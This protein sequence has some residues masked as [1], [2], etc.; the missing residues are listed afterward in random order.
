MTSAADLVRVDRT[1]H[2]VTL[3]LDRPQAHNA[4]STVMLERL[5]AL[6]RDLAAAGPDPDRPRA[7]V[8]TGAGR[9]FCSG[10]DT[11]EPDW[12]DIARRAVRRDHFRA[13]LT[14]LHRL[15]FPTVAAVEGYALGGGLEVALACDLVVA[16]ESAVFGLPEL[17]VGAVPGGGGVHSLVQRAG[18]GVAADL[19]LTG[20]RLSGAELARRGGVERLAPDG[21]ALTAALELAR[22]LAGRDPALLEA[23][24]RLLRDSGALDRTTALGVEDGYWWRG[25]VAAH[26]PVPPRIADSVHS[27]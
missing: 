25:A 19:L 24:V 21:G 23:G 16:A 11:R 4:L 6:M 9:S 13:V 12:H 17:T 22:P 7:L 1:G 8:L 5:A 10:A 2:V 18:R 15:P 27:E 26:R 14:A 20:G 3:T